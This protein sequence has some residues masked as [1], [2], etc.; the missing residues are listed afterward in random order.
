[1]PGVSSVLRPQRGYSSLAAV[2]DLYARFPHLCASAGFYDA[3]V[4][5]RH[6]TMQRGRDRRAQRHRVLAVWCLMLLACANSVKA[7][8]A[9]RVSRFRV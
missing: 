8:P 3:R 2:S 5:C 6:R 4:A 9:A 1:M 7:L